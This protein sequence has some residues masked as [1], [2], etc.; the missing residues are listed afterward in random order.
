MRIERF[1]KP[2]TQIVHPVR[3][4]EKICQ[5]HDQLQGSLFLD[6]SLNFSPD[7]PCLLAIFEGDVLAGAMTF[8]APTQEEAE[9]VG[10][11]H[12]DYRRRGVFRAL[13]Q[14]AAKHATRLQIP[15]FL[16]V[17]EPQSKNGVAA[18]KWFASTP[19][20]TEY[21]L[22]YDRSLPPDRL[23]VPA[24]LTMHRAAAADLADMAMIS[25]ESFSEDADRA[26]HFMQLALESKTRRQFLFRLDGEPVAI[27]ALGFEDGESTLYGLGV[28]THL[29]N[30]GIGRGIVSLLLQESF[31]QGVADIL[32]EV[33][34]TNAPAHHLYLSCGFVQEA[35]YDYLRAPV[36]QFLPKEA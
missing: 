19:D 21:A 30:R 9:I 34:N 15:D 13:V 3:E 8:F 23:P 17:C 27:G 16:F 32:I 29:Q 12:P 6:P 28:R 35:V 18:L 2:D 7:I 5:S 33:D 25:A 4:L 31:A 11:T 22:R 10:F 36:A 26:A 20:H 1:T 14:E 24:G